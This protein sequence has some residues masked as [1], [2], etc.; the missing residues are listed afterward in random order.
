MD[1]AEESEKV[2]E[3]LEKKRPM[4]SLQPWKITSPDAP[5]S[6]A[7]H[8]PV[9][10]D[11][12]EEPTFSEDMV[13]ERKRLKK[14]TKKKPNDG[15]V[16]EKPSPVPEE[17]EVD[18]VPHTTDVMVTDQGQIPVE[19]ESG[20]GQEVQQEQQQEQEQECDPNAYPGEW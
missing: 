1:V 7:F 4:W 3:K 13:E 17:E 11:N 20:E 10:E 5:H 9:A 16:D 19:Q 15:V 2:E 8:D 12:D 6:G 14:A 18:V